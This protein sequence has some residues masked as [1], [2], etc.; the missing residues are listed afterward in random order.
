MHLKR[1]NILLLVVEV[2]YQ[3]TIRKTILGVISQLRLY[4]LTN[5]DINSCIAWVCLSQAFPKLQS[6]THDPNNQCVV[7]WEK[8]AFVYDLRPL[9]LHDVQAGLKKAIEKH[10]SLIQSIH[11]NQWISWFDSQLKT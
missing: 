5:P 1:G 8:F 10:E 6:A 9:N 3:E 2:R 7:T 11:K 4:R